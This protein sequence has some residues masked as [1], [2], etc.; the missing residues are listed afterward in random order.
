MG[1]SMLCAR[2]Q[3]LAIALAGCTMV[4]PSGATSSPFATGAVTPA[5]TAAISPAPTTATATATASVPAA[6]AKRTLVL[7]TDVAGDDIV[8]I[9]FLVSAPSVELV[10]ITVSGTGEAHCAAGVDVVLRLLD[11]LDAPDI[12]VACG[13]ETPLTGAHEF[14]AA[15]REHVD[16]GSGLDLATTSRVASTSSAVE[17]INQ[18]SKDHTGLHVLT[19]GPLTNLADAFLADPHL[20]ARLGPV[21]TMGGALHVPGNLTCC[22]APEGNASAEWNIYV[23]PHA[24]AVVVESGIEPLLVSLDSTNHVPVTTALAD[25]A[26]HPATDAPAARLVADLF[27]ANQFMRLGEYY[28]WDPLAAMVAAGYPVGSQTPAVITVIEDEGTASGATRPSDGPPN[29]RFL[30]DVDGPVALDL[31]LRVLA[32]G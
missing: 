8:A 20:A 31:L 1:R 9:A 10:A 32:G 29:I 5:P 27:F 4:G 3:L 19:T 11:R 26:T 18:L 14:P 25:R 24:A 12:P 30:T 22:G 6:P 13:R 16:G 28:L 21:T 23:D 15:W 17:L 7:D 2:L